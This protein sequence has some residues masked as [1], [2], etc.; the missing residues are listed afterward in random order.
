[1]GEKCLHLRFSLNKVW[2]VIEMQSQQIQMKRTK[3]WIK[4]ITTTAAIVALP[5]FAAAQ[6]PSPQQ[7]TV[8]AATLQKLQSQVEQLS[9]EVERL[10]EG[11]PTD[12]TAE[13][14]L[15]FNLLKDNGLRI[16]FYGEAKYRFPEAGANKFD[17]HRFV[18]TPSYRITDWLIFNSEIE[19]EHGAVD[20][21]ANNGRNRFDGELELEQ[22]FV[23]I[24]INPHFNIRSPGIDLVPVGRINK[25]HE[26]TVFY[27]TERPELYREI[28]PSTWFEPSMGVFGQ[29]IDNL[30]YQLMISTG[31]EDGIETPGSAASG[32]RPAGWA[33]PGVDGVAGMRNA[34]PRLRNASE[35]NLAYSGRLHY[36]GIE[37]F[38]ASVSGY[39][40]RVDGFEGDSSYLALGDVEFA[41]RVLQT[42]LELRGDFA[43][44]HIENPENL[45]ANNNGPANDDIGERMLGWYVEAAYHFWPEAWREGKGKEMDFVPFIRYSDIRTQSDMP[46]GS[47]DVNDGTR[48]KEFLTF[49][50]SY[51]LNRNFVVKA[52]WRRNLNGH[53]SARFDGAAQDYFQ[54]GAGLFF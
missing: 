15:G 17:P 22:F 47:D 10:K 12:P 26:P 23:D 34:R 21:S 49:G 40:T 48:N 19:L 46:N 6:T 13:K 32:S 30:D 14:A 24:L 33:G 45:V 11:P 16:G 31:L 3:N 4:S 9:K 39:M 35:N 38:D 18:L 36:N 41:Y 2:S 5:G 28:I 8:D 37:G 54:L 29:V 44:W 27:S 25:F 52:D 53:R 7:V 43:Y 20:E 50:A 1:V 42:G 51:F